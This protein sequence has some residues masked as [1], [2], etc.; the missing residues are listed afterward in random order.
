MYINEITL[1]SDNHMRYTFMPVL[2][3]KV[4][5]LSL[6]EFLSFYFH[7]VNYFGNFTFPHDLLVWSSIRFDAIR[8]SLI[9][10]QNRFKPTI[11][12]QMY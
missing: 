7:F 2:Y 1:P 6:A 5:I 12:A 9:M 10:A 3:S 8:S 4:F 11:N